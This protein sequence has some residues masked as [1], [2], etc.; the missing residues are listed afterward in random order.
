[1]NTSV[2]YCPLNKNKGNNTTRFC[3]RMIWLHP[4]PLHYQT[5]LA[6]QRD[7]K[8]R[9]RSHQTT[10]AVFGNGG[11]DWSQIIRQQK[12]KGLFQYMS[13]TIMSL[14]MYFP[15]VALTAK[16]GNGQSFCFYV[17]WQGFTAKSGLLVR[18]AVTQ[19]QH[20]YFS[21]T[22]YRTKTS[23]FAFPLSLYK[24]GWRSLRL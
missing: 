3:C 23:Y 1:M 2:K 22:K 11:G 17:I 15:L 13:S 21:H 12:N 4:Q 20:I 14:L 7:E 16:F 6:I 5:L 8:L 9:E 24:I 18:G 10:V 19:S